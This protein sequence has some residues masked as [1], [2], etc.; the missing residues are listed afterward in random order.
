M[1]LLFWAVVGDNPL[2]NSNLHT[3]WHL[4]T[5]SRVLW[6]WGGLCGVLWV[7]GEDVIDISLVSLLSTLK[8]H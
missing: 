7:C 1:T 6:R 3:I 8:V 5:Q 2:G 4:P